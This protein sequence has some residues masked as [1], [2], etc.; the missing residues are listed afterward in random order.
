MN[1]RTMLRLG[2][3]VNNTVEPIVDDEST[4]LTDEEV[5]YVMSK[6][7]EFEKKYFTDIPI[8]RSLTSMKKF[9]YNIPNSVYRLIKHLDGSDYEVLSPIFMLYPLFV[10]NMSMETQS[11][12]LSN[13]CGL[14]G[15]ILDFDEDEFDE[16]EENYEDE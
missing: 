16:E 3:T 6:L 13:L 12:Y 5:A 11:E 8:S 10:K 9:V 4:Y 15:V 2:S 7:V 1:Y 14:V